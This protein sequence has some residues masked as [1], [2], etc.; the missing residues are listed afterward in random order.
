MSGDGAACVHVVAV[1][2]RELDITGMWKVGHREGATMD[3]HFVYGPEWQL[4]SAMVC[5]CILCSHWLLLTGVLEFKGQQY[6]GWSVISCQSNQII[7]ALRQHISLT[8]QLITPVLPKSAILRAW[9][10][11]SSQKFNQLFL[12]SLQSYP[13]NFIEICS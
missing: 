2:H 10:S 9:W 3:F 4:H 1:D 13:E 12:V 5:P 11:R 6:S 7:R 8:R